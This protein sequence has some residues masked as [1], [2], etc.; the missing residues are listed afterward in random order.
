MK[1]HNNHKITFNFIFYCI[2]HLR[3]WHT[4]E[5]CSKWLVAPLRDA[6]TSPPP[7]SY[8]GRSVEKNLPLVLP[9][10]LFLPSSVKTSG[11]FFQI[12]VDFSEKLNQYQAGG[13]YCAPHITIPTSRLSDLPTS[14]LLVPHACAALHF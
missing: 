5:E 4:R 1:Y 13:A 10:Q 6:G 8:F 7:L 2:P 12:F 9:K 11:R 14:L 3:L